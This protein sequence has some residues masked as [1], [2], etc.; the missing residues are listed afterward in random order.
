MS[1][2][3]RQ[4]FT[5]DDLGMLERVPIMQAFIISRTM[6]MLRNFQAGIIEEHRLYAALV[7]DLTPM[8]LPTKSPVEVPMRML[9]A[10]D[11]MMLGTRPGYRFGGQVSKNQASPHDRLFR[12]GSGTSP[13]GRMMVEGY[14]GQVSEAHNIA[15]AAGG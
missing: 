3:F 15:P 10:G 4:Y 13:I 7:D 2:E 1:S 6:G 9:A 8:E 5:N 12:H 11:L 14:A